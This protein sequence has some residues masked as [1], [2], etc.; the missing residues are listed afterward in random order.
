MSNTDRLGA[1]THAPIDCEQCRCFGM[2]LGIGFLL[3]VPLLLCA[4]L[5]AVAK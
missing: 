1:Q 3:L 2:I 5:A 4:T